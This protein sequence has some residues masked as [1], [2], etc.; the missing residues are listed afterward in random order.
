MP[1]NEIQEIESFVR[2]KINKIVAGTKIVITGSYR[3]G[4]PTSG[5][6]DILM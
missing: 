1:R 3:R 6:I 4:K 2:K 5:D